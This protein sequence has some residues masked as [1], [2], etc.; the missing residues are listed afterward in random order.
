MTNTEKK[1][2]KNKNYIVL[3]NQL[4]MHAGKEMLNWIDGFP[5]RKRD[6]SLCRNLA[7]L[8]IVFRD[9]SSTR[10]KN[11]MKKYVN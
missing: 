10:E 11:W 3:K 1:P 9:L 8:T 7:Q 2:K 6:T 4:R 5:Q